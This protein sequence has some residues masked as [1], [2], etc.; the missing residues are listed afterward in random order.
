MASVVKEF[1][2]RARSLTV[3]HCEGDAA[4]TAEVKT[5][6]RSAADISERD[7]GYLKVA[8][9]SFADADTAEGARLFL[10]TSRLKPR[11]EQD[12][13]TQYFLEKYEADL[14]VCADG[15]GASA[16][17]SYEVSAVGDS[18]LDESAGEGYHR[19]THHVRQRGPVSKMPFIK[20]SVRLRQNLKLLKYFLGLGLRGKKVIRFE[21]RRWSRV[22]QTSPRMQWSCKKMKPRSV[23]ERVYHMDS[24]AEEPWSSICH[25][26]LAPGQGPPPPDLSVIATKEQKDRDALR[27][28]YLQCVL[29]PGRVYTVQIPV[30]GLA[31]DGA[32]IEK[33]EK[34][35]FE[36]MSISSGKSRP[37]VMPTVLSH[38]QL[39]VTGKL[40]LRVQ[41][42]SESSVFEPIEWGGMV[43]EDSDPH[44][45][46]WQDLGPWI[47]VWKTL[48]I[49]SEVRALEE[50]SCCLE[51]LGCHPVECP[52]DFTNPQC[53]TLLIIFELHK[54][55]WRLQ[56]G[57]TVVH[58]SARIGKM[59]G[60]ESFRMKKYF[61]VLI[62]IERCITLTS[63]IPSDWYVLFY[64]LLLAG[65]RVEPGLGNKRYREIKKS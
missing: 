31:E 18:P 4:L 61:M 35:F 39:S 37:H 38:D 44:W 8:P 56:I 28:E 26:I 63:S 9:W 25:R 58:N 1:R 22:L 59:D 36:L 50:D 23:F 17:L 15:G 48:R 12:E 54:R 2:Q 27:M 45:L 49:V 20:Q 16:S 10:H 11:E 30:A 65:H 6:L 5:V 33:K 19:S 7:H 52:F 3:Q 43:C 62:Q 13:L 34:K 14:E 51:L 53:P 32:S 64:E 41:E 29:R 42:M 24:K 21:W 57:E 55:G 60:R 40:V 46:P 47:H